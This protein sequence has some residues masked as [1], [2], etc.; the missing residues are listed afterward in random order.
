MPLFA[1][2]LRRPS[3]E[4]TVPRAWG[5]FLADLGFRL[6]DL[7]TARLGDLDVLLVTVSLVAALPVLL[8]VGAVVGLGVGERMG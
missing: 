1:L 5:L 3:G 2:E 6:G 7:E 4:K 8:A